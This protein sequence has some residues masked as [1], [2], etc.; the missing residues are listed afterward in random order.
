MK[1]VMILIFMV[2]LMQVINSKADRDNNA[3]RRADKIVK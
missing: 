3:M 2:C 1:N